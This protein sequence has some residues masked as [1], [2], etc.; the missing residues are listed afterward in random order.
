MLERLNGMFAIAIADTRG[1][2]VHLVRDRVGIK[3]L[4]WTQCG[5][6]VL[7]AS[8]AK[9][10][11]AHPGFRAEIDPAEVDELLAFRHVA[12]EASLLKGVR[13]VQPGHR[14]AITP[15][16]VREVRYWSIPDHSEKLHLSREDAVDRLG[17]LLG[18]SVQSH[19]RSDVP[20]GCQLSGGVDS[21]LVTVLAGGAQGAQSAQVTSADLQR[22][23]DRL[24]R[25]AIL[26]RAV[27]PD[28]GGRGARHEPS[29]RV[30]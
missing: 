13:H 9:A 15:D 21:S 7:F 14:L 16:G 23:L 4:Y 1:G 30:R 2:V 10:F 5:R 24:R 12:G 3:P 28:G 17:R 27:D 6:A 19:L 29:V 25:T 26:G 8:E 20:T 11:L 18:R 22:L